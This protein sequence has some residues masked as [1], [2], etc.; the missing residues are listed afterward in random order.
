MDLF[1]VRAIEVSKLAM[2]GLVKRQSAIASN[3]ANAMTPDYQRKMVAF[4][5]QLQE[6]IEKD[7]IRK[8]LLMKKTIHTEQAILTTTIQ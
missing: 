6:I 2:D 3:T 7:D 8:D 4:E 5:D 1:N